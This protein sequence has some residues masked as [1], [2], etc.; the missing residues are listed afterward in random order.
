MS[1][2]RPAGR[3]GERLRCEHCGYQIP[4]NVR[5]SEDGRGFCSQFCLEA[6]DEEKPVPAA[7]AYQRFET[8]IEPLDELVPSGLPADAFVLLSGEE[9]TRRRELL[10]EFVWRALER[11]EPAVYVAYADPP[12]AV[13]ERFFTLGWNPLPALEDDRLRI[14]DCFTHRLEDRDA[15]INTL[16]D[17]NRFLDGAANDAIEAVRDPTDVREVANTLNRS[18]E[19]LKMTESGLVVLDSLDELDTM[20]QDRLV[21]NFVTDVRAVVSKARFVPIVASATT[22][23][24]GSYPANDEYVFDGIV[25]LRLTGEL[26]AEMRLRQLG[27]RK[28][29]GTAFT[30]RWIAYDGAPGSGAFAFDPTTEIPGVYDSELEPAPS[31]MGTDAW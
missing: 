6:F 15:F 16:N 24:E 25:E 31:R 21:H 19:D 26:V 10:T 14:L 28:L 18:L 13:L 1:Q 3:P 11:G 12:T 30:P 4:G 2:S 29:V 23:T 22:S 8:G 5:R 20:I 7:D 17:W 27:I 9:G